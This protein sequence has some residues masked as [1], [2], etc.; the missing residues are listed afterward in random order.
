MRILTIERQ[1]KVDRPFWDA[2]ARALSREGIDFG[3]PDED[4]DSKQSSKSDP[5][6]VAR[7]GAVLPV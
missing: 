3:F 1:E 5:D 4:H 2:A 6:T 7:V